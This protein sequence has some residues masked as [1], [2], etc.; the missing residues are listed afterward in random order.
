MPSILE[1]IGT[2][3][4]AALCMLGVIAAIMG[5]YHAF[6]WLRKT[7]RDPLDNHNTDD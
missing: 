3:P 7:T 1:A 2:L 6:A 4:L 5:I